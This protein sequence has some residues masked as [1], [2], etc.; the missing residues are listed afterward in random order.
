MVKLPQTI[1]REIVP[2]E[3]K[4]VTLQYIENAFTFSGYGKTRTRSWIDTYFQIGVLKAVPTPTGEP[5]R[6]TCLWW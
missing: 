5:L 2:G 6:V 4:T 1:L 3:D